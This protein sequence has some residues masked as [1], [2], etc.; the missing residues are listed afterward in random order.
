MLFTPCPGF[1]FV[2]TTLVSDCPSQ[3]P[4]FYLFLPSVWPRVQG[5]GWASSALRARR[6]LGPF[7]ALGPLG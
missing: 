6:L 2:P 4:F 5:T 3:L 1:L 7:C